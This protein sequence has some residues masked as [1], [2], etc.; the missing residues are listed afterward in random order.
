MTRYKVIRIY[1]VE[2]EKKFKA[3]EKVRTTGDEYL[4]SEFAVDDEAGAGWLRTF[5]KQL[6][7]VKR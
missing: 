4:D 5:R 2:A 3:V 1:F 7:G 6:F